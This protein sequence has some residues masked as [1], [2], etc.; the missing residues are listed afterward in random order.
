LNLDLRRL[1]MG[2]AIVRKHRV[3]CLAVAAYE[4]LRAALRF[5]TR[6]DVM[7]MNTRMA[8]STELMNLPSNTRRTQSLRLRCVET[9][10]G[11]AVLQEFNLT[12]H[13]FRKNA[14]DGR[15]PGIFKANW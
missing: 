8:A 3:A 11:R 1:V 9:G 4:P 14:L 2:Q 13:A 7:P 6:C 12:R 5:I 10:R 15:I